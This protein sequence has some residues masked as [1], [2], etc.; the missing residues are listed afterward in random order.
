MPY[1]FNNNFIPFFNN[2]FNPFM[3]HF[4]KNINFQTHSSITKNK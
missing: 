2:Q 1:I 3:P 4:Y